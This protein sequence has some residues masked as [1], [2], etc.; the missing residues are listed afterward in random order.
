[1]PLHR[2]AV[3]VGPRHTGIHMG[4]VGPRHTMAHGLPAHMRMGE[5]G[6]LK[7]VHTLVGPWSHVPLPSTSN[8][9]LVPMM[10]KDWSM[11]DY[12]SPTISIEPL[13]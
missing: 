8:L 13:E 5:A 9:S 12:Q 10:D 1:M 7:Q 4:R 11:M 6:T 3:R 2:L